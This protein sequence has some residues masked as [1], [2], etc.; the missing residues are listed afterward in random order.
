MATFMRAL[1]R[2]KL[3]RSEY[4]VEWVAVIRTLHSAVIY[5]SCSSVMNFSQHDCMIVGE[6]VFRIILVKV[7]NSFC[8][9]AF[10]D[11]VFC[12]RLHP[13]LCTSASACCGASFML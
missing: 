6:V 1:T 5:F 2:V 4:A 3:R 12:Q 10:C 11:K 8:I 13:V 9:I 7:Q